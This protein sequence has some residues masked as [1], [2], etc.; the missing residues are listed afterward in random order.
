MTSLA[1]AT[2]GSDYAKQVGLL[3][4]TLQIYQPSL[5]DSIQAIPY[6]M[7]VLSYDASSTPLVWSSNDGDGNVVAVFKCQSLPSGLS[8][9]YYPISDLAISQYG[10]NAPV[11]PSKVAYIAARGAT[12]SPPQGY[13]FVFDDTGSGASTDYSGYYTVPP[14]IGSFNAASDDSSQPDNAN[15]IQLCEGTYY[16]QVELGTNIWQSPSGAYHWNEDGTFYSHPQFGMYGAYLIVRGHSR[17]DPDTVPSLPISAFSGFKYKGLSSTGVGFQTSIPSTAQLKF[18]NV[19]HGSA[20]SWWTDGGI[21]PFLGID[22]ST[23][24]LYFLEYESVQ[25]KFRL[26]AAADGGIYFGDFIA[27]TSLVDDIGVLL[28]IVSA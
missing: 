6:E 23:G 22:S 16:T 19:P 28:S 9:D 24:G 17:P 14:G 27:Q 13:T 15:L 2:F 3:I 25:C 18:C 20:I 7:R 1:T 21:A 26:F 8:S 10:G 5:L 11:L 12:L 4:S